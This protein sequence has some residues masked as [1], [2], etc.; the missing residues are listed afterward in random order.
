MKL[1]RAVKEPL[2]L[3]KLCFYSLNFKS[4]VDINNKLDGEKSEWF[5]L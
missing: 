4:L 1:M 2:Q 5:N 3:Q